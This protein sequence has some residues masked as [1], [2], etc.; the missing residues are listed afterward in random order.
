MYSSMAMFHQYCNQ[1]IELKQDEVLPM[2]TPARRAKPSA[3]RLN[4]IKTMITACAL[5]VVVVGATTFTSG[6][7]VIIDTTPSSQVTEAIF[8]SGPEAVIDAVAG[9][10]VT[11]ALESVV[12]AMIAPIVNIFSHSSETNIPN[13]IGKRS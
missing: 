10:S 1:S 5:I 11:E 13:A 6:P 8:A 4:I 12:S 9:P 3:Q 7:E 2:I